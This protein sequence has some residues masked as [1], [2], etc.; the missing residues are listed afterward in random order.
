MNGGR[1]E[2]RKNKNTRAFT[3]GLHFVFAWSSFETFLWAHPFFKSIDSVCARF[4]PSMQLCCDLVE[5]M[6][7]WC[8]SFFSSFFFEPRHNILHSSFR[9]SL[10]ITKMSLDNSSFSPWLQLR[11]TF[12]FFFILNTLFLQ[13]NETIKKSF[14]KWNLSNFISTFSAIQ[15]HFELLKFA[16]SDSYLHGKPKNVLEMHVF[17]LLHFSRFFFCPHLI[18]F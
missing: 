5:C 7:C 14:T 15:L 8:N 6:L 17:Y 16:H 18:F 11:H 4:V 1:A 13:M 12:C 9:L 10:S 3:K 2:K